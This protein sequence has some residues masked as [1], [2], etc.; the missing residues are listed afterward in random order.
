MSRILGIDFGLARIGL[1][2]SDPLLLFARGYLTLQNKPNKPER[3]LEIITEI[4]A[5][6]AKENVTEIVL[7]LPKRTDG[8]VST[9]EE[10]ARQFGSDLGAATKLPIHYF[11]ERFTTVIAHQILNAS[12][13]KRD[14]HAKR[15]V[16]DQVAAEIILQNYLDSRRK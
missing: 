7:G 1:A 12:S 8:K 9:S 16:V 15:Q 6:I 13:K 14:S 4:K 5:I 11:D 2:L 10:L 3:L